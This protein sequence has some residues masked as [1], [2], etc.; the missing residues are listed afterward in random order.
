MRL[1][2]AA[3][4][5]HPRTAPGANRG[6]PG[7]SST[8]T[9]SVLAPDGQLRQVALKTGLS[10]ANYIEVVSGDLKEGEQVVVG[11]SGQAATSTSPAAQPGRRM[12]F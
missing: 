1:P 8:Q 7:A 10:D 11:M 3:L 4:R 6:A 12:G 9:V 5:F 2:K